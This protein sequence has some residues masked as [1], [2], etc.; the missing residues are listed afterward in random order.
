MRHGI[1]N[2]LF[3]V[4][5]FLQRTM[6]DMEPQ[7][8]GVSPPLSPSLSLY[9]SLTLPPS[10]SLPHPPSLP[11][12]LPHPP[13]LHHPF[14]LSL[15]TSPTAWREAHQNGY[16]KGET[17]KAGGSEGDR[18]YCTVQKLYC[19]VKNR[20]AESKKLYCTVKTR[21]LLYTMTDMEPQSIAMKTSVTVPHM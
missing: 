3:Q 10:P 12:S 18:V 7:S 19:A 4:A 1:S 13:S 5:L 11:P 14:S 17:E 8:I 15:H 21:A 6:T 2:S 16:G 20:T 9:P